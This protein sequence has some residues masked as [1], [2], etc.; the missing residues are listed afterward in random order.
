MTWWEKDDSEDVSCSCWAMSSMPKQTSTLGESCI[1]CLQQRMQCTAAVVK[2]VAM[3]SSRFGSFW[4]K[5]A[6]MLANTPGMSGHCSNKEEVTRYREGKEM[7]SRNTL[8]SKQEHFGIL[9]MEMCIQIFINHCHHHHHKRKRGST[10]ERQHI[11]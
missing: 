2:P 11:R 3:F 6:D 5:C 4:L 8:A 9:R 10:C 1:P 7:G